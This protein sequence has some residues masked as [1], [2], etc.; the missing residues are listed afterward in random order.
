MRP[1]I[2]RIA[3]TLLVCMIAV[4]SN[5]S[6]AYP[7]KGKTLTIVVPFPPGATSDVSAR[8]LAAALEDD[9]GIT[10]KVINKPGATT[11]IGS[12]E[13]ARAKPDGYKIGLAS[14]PSL[15]VTYLDKKRKAPYS[16][17]SFTPIAHYIS[18]SNVFAVMNDSPFETISD[19]VEAAIA[20]P[21]TVRVGTVGLMS[22]SHL[23]GLAIE[24]ETGA[25]F[26][27]V[28]FNGAAPLITALLAGDVD[29]AINA[30]LTT[31]PHVKAG[32]MRAIGSFGSKRSPFL[33]DAPTLIE[34]GI[35]I[36]QPTSFAI[37]GPAGL[38]DDVIKTLTNA[39]KVAV[40][41]PEFQTK[42]AEVALVSD[43]MDPPTLAKYWA[44]FDKG[45]KNLIDLARSQ[46]D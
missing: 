20:K 34:Q 6:F 2:V 35:N 25:Q 26:A 39:I 4:C 5:P 10:V 9:L 28:H 40:E 23:P 29:V 18:G 1:S 41:R 33:P 46:Q 44:E 3:S 7:D 42:L 24:R 31:V 11:Q 45:Q 12:M 27:F 14:L 16:N 30:E 36:T 38:S 37:I 17:E 43:Y 32:N 8:M 21:K 15:A 22:N 19:L 13:V